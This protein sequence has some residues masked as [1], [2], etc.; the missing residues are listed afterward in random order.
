M[1]EAAV[2]R[3]IGYSDIG[4]RRFQRGARAFEPQVPNILHGTDAAKLLETVAQGTRRDAD[5][6]GNIDELQRFAAMLANK[7]LGA[8]D[9]SR[10]RRAPTVL[11]L[12]ICFAR[13]MPCR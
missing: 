2:E 13:C 12:R 8:L 7:L 9:E 10:R 11:R 6:A 4:P 1:R 5:G 3:D